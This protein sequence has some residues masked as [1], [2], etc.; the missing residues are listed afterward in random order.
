MRKSGIVTFETSY[1]DGWR[2]Y[3]SADL[4]QE[5]L[6]IQFDKWLLQ[7]EY[8]RVVGVTYSDDFIPDHSCSNS[9]GSGK[10]KMVVV[11]LIEEE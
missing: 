8:A 2:E 1:G 11:Y 4:A 10:V 3:S 5:S 9:D 6:R 7:N